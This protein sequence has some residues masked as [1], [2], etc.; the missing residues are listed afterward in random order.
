MRRLHLVSVAVVLVLAILVSACNGGP[1]PTATI[2]AVSSPEATTGSEIAEKDFEDFDPGNFDRPATVDN[3]WFPLKPGTQFIYEGTTVEDDGTVVPHRVE[4]TV[5]DLTKVIGGVRSVVSW[6]Q[7][8]SD[9]ELVEAELAFFAQD[10]DGNVWRMGEY[11]EEY[12]EGKFVE[13][14]TWIHGLED[15]RAGIMMRADPQPGTPSYSEGWGPAVDWTDRGQVDQVGQETCV[16]A[17]CYND[18]LAIAESSRSEPGAFQ[19]KYYAPGVGNIQVGWRG[20]DVTQEKLE[21]VEIVQ[22]SPEALAEAR[23]KALGLEKHAYEVSQDV[24]VYTSPAEYPEGTPLLAITPLVPE[25]PEAGPPEAASSEIIVYSSDLPENTLF[26]MDFVEDPASPGGKM[27]SLPNNGDEL[28]PPPESDP[29]VTFT[30]QVQSGI[31]YRCW[32][33]MKVGEPFGVSQ[34]NVIYAQFTD[35]VDEANNE[36]L[37]VG[38]GSYLT[39][40][41]PT[42]LGWAW[43]ECDRAD[44]EAEP[45][46]YFRTDGEVTVRLQ[47]GMEGVGFDQFLLSPARFLDQPPTEPIV[48]K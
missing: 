14:P 35:A 10:N 26:E 41:G 45:L 25:T 47:A 13:A 42:Q 2:E 19:L 22:L 29:H 7:D 40:E 3:Q 24:Y 43:V 8:Y 32:I 46:V 9:G 12:E 21:L 38:T 4:I 1:S 6:D 28:D 15:A 37:N 17:D 23:A 31:P 18:V 11:P 34:A 39:A 44:S 36:I 33:H 16:P 30:I 5:T 48:E 27:I 20:A